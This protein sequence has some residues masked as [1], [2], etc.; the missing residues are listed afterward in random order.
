MASSDVMSDHHRMNDL[1]FGSLKT[2]L[3]GCVARLGL[4]DGLAGEQLGADELATRLGTHPDAT[5]RLLRALCAME[6]VAEAAPGVYRLTGLGEL[7]RTDR[8]DSVSTA[9]LT[10][11]DP[12]MV[13]AWKHPDQAVRTGRP[14]F[15]DIYGTTFFE[16]IAA[17]PELSERFNTTMR[18]ITLPIALAL[19][20]A[21]DFSRFATVADVGGGNGTVLAELLRAHPGLRGLLYDSVEGV[22]EA[23]AT[24]AAAGVEERCEVRPG[25]FFAEVP[26]GCD[27]YLLKSILHDWDDERCATILRNCRKAIAADGRLLMV[28]MVL[29]DAVKPADATLYLS[30]VNMLINMG[31]KERTAAEFE[32]LCADAGFTVVARHPVPGLPY[33]VVEAV[34]A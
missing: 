25:D 5:A 28:E 7:L 23:P 19:P 16:F 29:P 27:A 31:G 22:A 14:T 6:L 13:D 10:F 12:E 18:Q 3:V 32:V 26:A 33:S 9:V 17:R 21:Y 15:T 1:L 8:P 20:Q 4:A 34:P 11:T 2:Q 24:L 30:D